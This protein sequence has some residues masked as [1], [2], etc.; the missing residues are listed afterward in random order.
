MTSVEESMA[1]RIL[2]IV[3]I[4]NYTTS[5]DESMAYRILNVVFIPNYIQ[6]TPIT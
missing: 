3:F 4:P 5:V 6:L 2:N 1:Y